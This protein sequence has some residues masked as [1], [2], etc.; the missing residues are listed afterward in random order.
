MAVRGTRTVGK[1]DL[2][3]NASCP[4]IE[5]DPESYTVLADGEL[6]TCEPL[7]EVPLAQRYFPF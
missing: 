1:A 3:F 6:L 5:I 2:L 7:A 4:E